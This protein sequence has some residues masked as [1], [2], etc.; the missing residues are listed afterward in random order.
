[1]GL[2][3]GWM[4]LPLL[5][6]TLDEIATATLH[7]AAATEQ[8]GRPRHLPCSVAETFPLGLGQQRAGWY[9][10]RTV[11]S[12]AVQS[13]RHSS[14]CRGGR[15][16]W[17]GMGPWRPGGGSA[18]RCARRGG[19]GRGRG[20]SLGRGT[21]TA[22]RCCL[23]LDHPLAPSPSGRPPERAFMHAC[24]HVQTMQRAQNN[25]G[26]SCIAGSKR[27]ARLVTRPPFASAPLALPNATQRSAR[28]HSQSKARMQLAFELQ[29]ACIC[30]PCCQQ[31]YIYIFQTT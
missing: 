14:R 1:M 15:V 20:K 4:R 21:R 7:Y 12:P 9:I 31:L 2:V 16:K 10:H 13:H 29:S 19:V 5:L 30:M 17:C 27:L 3:H 22:V 25:A 23:W 18:L 11:R 26:A 24:M 6:R 8:W 28:V